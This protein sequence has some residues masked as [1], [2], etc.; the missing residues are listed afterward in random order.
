[1][2]KQ[3][4]SRDVGPNCDQFV[5][6]VLL[7][8][9]RDHEDVLADLIASLLTSRCPAVASP[10]KRKRTGTRA[11]AAP[12]ADRILGHLDRLR[13][14]TKQLYKFDAMQ[15]ALQQAQSS[16]TESQKSQFSNL[17][18]LVEVEENTTGRGKG[19]RGRRPANPPPKKKPTKGGVIS[20]LSDISSEV[21][22]SAVIFKFYLFV[23]KDKYVYFSSCKGNNLLVLVYNFYFGWGKK[24]IFNSFTSRVYWEK[25]PLQPTIYLC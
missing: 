22:I 24:V 17:F 18:A 12:S 15:K 11:S 25:H 3:V 13:T 21:R 16:C 9:C 8:W 1:M 20:D 19:G 7:S 2:V 4:L 6:S 10:N 23:Y 14:G 5:I